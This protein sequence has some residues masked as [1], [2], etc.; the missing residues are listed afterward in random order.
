MEY[1]ILY[2]ALCAV[3]HFFYESIVA[4]SLRRKLRY[5][6]FAVR[7]ELRRAKVRGAL[8]DD[9]YETLQEVSNNALN[10]L[11]R[12][13]LMTLFSVYYRLRSDPQFRKA[14]KEQ[15]ERINQWPREAMPLY[16]RISHLF[17]E[18]FYINSFGWAF[19]LFPLIILVLLFPQ[20]GT[21]ITQA[22]FAPDPTFDSVAGPAHTRGTTREPA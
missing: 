12:I 16:N 5:H 20:I 6:F 1:L 9:V 10:R 3:W 14:V 7:D 11:D 8:T 17:D 15:R 19:Y 2:L 4:P 13:G 21:L 18:A 22:L